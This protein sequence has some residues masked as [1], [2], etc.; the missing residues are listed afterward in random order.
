MRFLRLFLTLCALSL[1]IGC[2]KGSD[3]GKT[4][5]AAEGESK[6]PSAKTEPAAKPPITK[7]ALL[8]TK[9]LVKTGDD[10][11]AARAKLEEVLGKSVYAEK[12]HQWW[13]VT[14]GDSCFGTTIEA[15]DG[16]LVGE[17]MAPKELKASDGNKYKHCVAAAARNACHRRGD[18]N[19]NT[20]HETA[21]YPEDEAMEGIELAG[22]E[23]NMGPAAG[24]T[25]VT[26]SGKGL[27]AALDKGAKVL[28]GKHE[29][30]A[31]EPGDEGFKIKAPAAKP[32]DYVD[33]VLVL[34]AGHREIIGTFAYMK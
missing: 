32:G 13:A 16:E 9:D 26:V 28:F 29:V 27:K 12:V 25:E 5:P 22:S 33:I 18:A 20:K 31:I 34:P 24:G 30:K 14:E 6:T 11:N 21:P 4:K 10:F 2:S 1:F 8:G 19:C 7:D 23:P 15:A 3:N 17:Y